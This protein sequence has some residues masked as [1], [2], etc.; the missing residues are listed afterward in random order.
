MIRSLV[1]ASIVIIAGVTG[2]H[3]YTQTKLLADYCF[4]VVG[5]RIVK[6]GWKQVIMEIDFQIYNKSDVQVTIDNYDLGIFINGNFVSKISNQVGQVIAPRGRSIVTLV[7]D[8]T[9]QQALAG[10]FNLDF[11]KGALNKEQI[12]VGISGAV[13]VSHRGIRLRNLPVQIELPLSEMIP[14]AGE[15]VPC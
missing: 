11:L 2:W 3:F 15:Q 9:P 1:I 8:F 10:I 12:I 6:V 7:V 4:N 14:K 13:T 5:H